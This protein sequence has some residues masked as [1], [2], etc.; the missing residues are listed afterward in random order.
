MHPA[1]NDIRLVV[2]LSL[3]LTEAVAA[4]AV[5]RKPTPKPSAALVDLRCVPW[6]LQIEFCMTAQ[7]GDEQWLGLA[8]IDKELYYR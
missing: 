3:L 8:G 4:A 1:V 7:S 5:L 6:S 2:R